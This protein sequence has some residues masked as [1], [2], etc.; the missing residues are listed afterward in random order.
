MKA[1]YL[2]IK[3]NQKKKSYKE[4]KK[5]ADVLQTKKDQFQNDQRAGV[6]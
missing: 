2:Y 4:D 3:R 5:Q 6:Y 1:K